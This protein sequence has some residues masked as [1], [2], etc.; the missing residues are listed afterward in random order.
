MEDILREPV[1]LTE[2]ELDEVAGGGSG[3]ESSCHNDCGGGLTVGI[4]VAIG[5]GLC[6]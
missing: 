4:V 6:L 2:A 5:V 3:C 1:E